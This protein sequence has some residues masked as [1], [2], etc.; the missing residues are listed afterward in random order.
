MSP[1]RIEQET[2]LGAAAADWLTELGW[3]V[4]QEVQL[5]RNGAVADLVAVRRR[6]VWALECKR[7]LS[8][9]LLEQALEWRP[10]AHYVSI[11]VPLPRREPKGYGFAA[12]A[13]RLTGLG[14]LQVGFARCPGEGRRLLVQEKV[15]PAVRRWVDSAKLLAGL[16]ERHKTFA[17]A[18]NARSKRWTPFQQTCEQLRALAAAE[19]GVLLSDCVRRVEHHYR[20]DVTARGTLA[21]WLREGVVSGCHVR[22]EEGRLRL[23][24]DVGWEDADGREP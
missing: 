8:L 5:E 16:H 9:K 22:K 20:S 24:P 21:R 17:R 7:S 2:E 12:E 19:P 13:M 6:V 3:E 15:K 11:V 23:Y 1:A 18:G 4:Y 10:L 14:W